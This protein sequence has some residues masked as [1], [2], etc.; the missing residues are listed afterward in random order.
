M[1]STPDWNKKYMIA[2]LLLL[3]AIAG[4]FFGVWFVSRKIRETVAD[5]NGEMARQRLREQRLDKMSGLESSY[6][7]VLK[8]KEAFS[9]T[10]PK[11]DTIRVITRLEGLA[12]TTD[13]EL[14]ITVAD[15]PKSLVAVK[16]KSKKPSPPAPGSAQTPIDPETEKLNALKEEVKKNES[17]TFS[18]KIRGSY[19]SVH[20]YL[21]KLENL[22][23]LVLLNDVVMYRET[24][25]NKTDGTNPFA[26][27]GSEKPSL[28]SS[29]E[30]TSKPEKGGDLIVAEVVVTFF[31]R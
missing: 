4:C 18:V 22:D 23:L 14:T 2:G 15:K 7:S 24:P 11:D 26:R 27:T 6:A 30:S 8:R 20:S 9:L 12:E 17:V 1:T 13:T 3:L 21:R 28:G 29:G 31:V 10:N 16:K 19:E 25:D 5:I